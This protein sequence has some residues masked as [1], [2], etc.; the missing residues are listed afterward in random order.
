MFDKSKEA[1]I[2]LE[3]LHCASRADMEAVGRVRN[4]CITVWMASLAA[5]N[6][7]SI[8]LT[9]WQKYLLPMMPLFLFWILE[10]FYFTFVHLRNAQILELEKIVIINDYE[11]YNNEMFMVRMNFSRFT[12]R[13]KLASFIRCLFTKESIIIFY[14]LLLSAS[15]IFLLAGK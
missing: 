11:S 2:L 12:L 5:I 8:S 6:S 7:D 13:D 4:W 9:Q 3:Q 1:R 15:A 10:S 14:G